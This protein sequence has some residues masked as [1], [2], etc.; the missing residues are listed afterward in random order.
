MP[1]EQDGL[2][3][4]EGIRQVDT[5]AF[6]LELE[7]QPTPWLLVEGTLEQRTQQAIVWIDAQLKVCLVSLI[8]ACDRQDAHSMLVWPG[9][10]HSGH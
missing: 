1:F 9:S 10:H 6:P 8:P 5:R 7:R 3:D 2:R 4:G